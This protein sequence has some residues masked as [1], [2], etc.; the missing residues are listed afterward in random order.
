MADAITL[1]YFAWV[2]ER[3]GTPQEKYHLPAAQT[4]TDILDALIAR[5]GNY[6]RAF[7][8]R[9]KIRFAVNQNY[10]A[11]THVVNAGDTLAIFPPVTGG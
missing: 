5:G 7:G 4:V 11:E 1:E 10:V 8:E 6:P 9:D 3:I 2:R